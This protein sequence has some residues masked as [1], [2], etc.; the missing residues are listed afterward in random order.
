MRIKLAITVLLLG[1]VIQ[2]IACR[3]RPAVRVEADSA[4]R[5]LRHGGRERTYVVRVPSGI[6]RDGAAAPLVIVLHGGGGNARNA[7]AMTGFTAKGAAERFVVVYP[8]GTSRGRPLLTWNAGHCCGYAMEQRVDDVD[9]IRAVIDDVSASYPIDRKRVYVTGMSNGAM[10]AHRLGIELSDR[11]AA[12]APVVGTIFGDEPRPRSPVS[13]LMINGVLDE[14]VPYRGGPPGGRFREAWDGTPTKPAL[15]QAR[16]WAA[17]NGCSSALH[18]EDRGAYQVGRHDC[19]PPIAVE[20]YS[21]EDNGHAWPGGR[22]G[23]RLGDTPSTS[24]NATDVIWAFFRAHPK[25]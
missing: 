11:V 9:F 20:I 25:P 3:A 7:E 22:S 21:V 6:S 15:D 1:S 18:T 10:M 13:A 14:F 24:L 12:I 16:F 17:V 19:M 23:S 2:I 5:V 4:Q 8:E